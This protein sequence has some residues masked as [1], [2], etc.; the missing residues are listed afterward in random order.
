[1]LMAIEGQ[2]RLGH[3]RRWPPSYGDTAGVAAIILN[4]TLVS[5]SEDAVTW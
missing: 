4:G 5:N 3:N 1:M 2:V